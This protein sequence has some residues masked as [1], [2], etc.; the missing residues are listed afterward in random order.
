MSASLI[1]AEFNGVGTAGMDIQALKPSAD[2]IYGGAFSIQVCDE[3]MATTAQYYYIPASESPDGADGWFEEDFATRV[4]KTL[5]SAEGFIFMSDFDDGE[6]ILT[7][8]GE[9]IFAEQTVNIPMNA[10]LLGNNRPVA[11]NIQDIAVVAD[12]NYGGAVSIQVCDEYM[13]TTAQ[14]YFIPADES[15]DGEDGWFDEDFATRTTLTFAPG[16]AFIIMSDFDNAQIKIPSI[17]L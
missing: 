10:S 4:V 16:E 12:G 13:A 15:P 5:N 1:T 8:A 6:G 17:A 11:L 7:T 14:Y 9:V 2:D 3:Y